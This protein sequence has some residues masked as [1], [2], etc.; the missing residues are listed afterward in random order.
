MCGGASVSRS[1]RAQGLGGILGL[2]GDVEVLAGH[3]DRSER[4]LYRMAAEPR[5]LLSAVQNGWGMPASD[6]VRTLTRG[7][8]RARMGP[9]LSFDGLGSG[10]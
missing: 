7:A 10:P 6:W 4:A 5:A 8:R 2:V 1:A 3:G 9:L